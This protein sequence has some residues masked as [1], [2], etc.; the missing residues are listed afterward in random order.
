MRS[1]SPSPVLSSVGTEP[2]GSSS[3]LP[4]IP[5]S[6]SPIAADKLF[7]REQNQIAA[8]RRPS[9]VLYSY[10][11]SDSEHPLHA[12][13]TRIL[14]SATMHDN[15]SDD[16]HELHLP[17]ELYQQDLHVVIE[18]TDGLHVLY[19]HGLSGVYL[20]HRRVR[21]R[22]GIGYALTDGKLVW[23]GHSSAFWYHIVESGYVSNS[24]LPPW[25]RNSRTQAAELL[26][27]ETKTPEESPLLS[28]SSS[29]SPLF[30]D[31]LDLSPAFSDC[32]QPVSPRRLPP[33]SP[34]RLSPKD[35]NNQ[36]KE[37]EYLPQPA[38]FVYAPNRVI[39][40]GDALAR[41]CNV[42]DETECATVPRYPYDPQ[43][44]EAIAGS[45]TQMTNNGDGDTVNFINNHFAAQVFAANASCFEI[46]QHAAFAGVGTTVVNTSHADATSIN[47]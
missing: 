44:L 24:P 8:E 1:A 21:V 28:N 4:G 40:I 12:G 25:R 11:G 15:Q 3:P 30:D 17:L 2:Y 34:L 13:R 47:P 20:G 32:T 46:Q 23:F 29:P 27:H 31:P 41:W 7:V 35:N 42:G 14:S 6:S 19:D 5:H 43:G 37:E 45:I 10:E 22:Q 33:V 36:D 18:I 39:L 16:T 38:K 26:A 9:A